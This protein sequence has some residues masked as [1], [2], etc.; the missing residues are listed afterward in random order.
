[1]LEKLLSLQAEY[2]ILGN[3]QKTNEG[4]LPNR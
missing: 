2:E 1:M 4:W 3:T